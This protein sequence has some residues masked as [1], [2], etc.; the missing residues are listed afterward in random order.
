MLTHRASNPPYTIYGVHHDRYECATQKHA[1]DELRLGGNGRISRWHK[2]SVLKYMICAETF[3]N[4]DWAAVAAGAAGMAVSMWQSIG[5][6]FEQVYR[7]SEAT[8]GIKYSRLPE[9]RCRD[10]YA[11][12][13]FPQE[14]PGEIY[15]YQFALEGSNANHLANILAH[16]LG[17]VLGLRHE[18]A[19]WRTSVLWGEK[20]PQSIMNYFDHP[21]KLKVGEQD[22]RELAAFYEYEQGEYEGQPVTDL[23]PP[24]KR[25]PRRG[26][27][28]RKWRC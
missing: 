21:S 2:G 26:S 24:L 3:D 4:P 20:N 15:I 14:A 22:R 9:S 1:E 5:V 27:W 19:H 13:F 6:R 12:A 16:E 25:F 23:A 11:R 18:F 28:W 8:F 17:H 10:V 7:D